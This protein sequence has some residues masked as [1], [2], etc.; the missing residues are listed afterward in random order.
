[1]AAVN[2]HTD[3]LLGQVYNFGVDLGNGSLGWLDLYTPDSDPQTMAL[4][5]GMVYS[6]GVDF[7]VPNGANTSAS[8]PQD[9][10]QITPLSASAVKRQ[11]FGGGVLDH[12]HNLAV[13]AYAEVN[14][15]GV[16]TQDLSL[17]NVATGQ[18]LKQF[19]IPLKGDNPIISLV[20]NNDDSKILAVT[21]DHDL[22]VI[23]VAAGTIQRQTDNAGQ[24]AGG[25]ALSSDGKLLAYQTTANTIR[26]VDTMNYQRVALFSN[27][28]LGHFEFTPDNKSLVGDSGLFQVGVPIVLD[29]ATAKM[30]ANA[31]AD[32]PVE[33]WR[34][35]SDGHY[36]GYISAKTAYLWDI[37]AHKSIKLGISSLATHTV[38]A[39]KQIASLT[40]SLDN[41]WVAYTGPERTVVVV[42]LQTLKPITTIKAASAIVSAVGFSKDGSVIIRCAG[43]NFDL[44][45]TTTGDLLSTI[46]DRYMCDKALDITWGGNGAYVILYRADVARWYGLSA[47]YQMPSATSVSTAQPTI[48][49]STAQPTIGSTNAIAACPGSPAP[50]LTIGGK[51]RVTPGNPNWI[52][53]A[54][55]R[56]STHPSQSKHIAQIPPGGVFDVLEGP[57][58]A[59]GITWWK[60]K[61]RGYT[62]WTGE[63]DSDYWVEPVN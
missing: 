28:Q 60:V 30:T 39:P 10:P 15:G 48:S 57:Q 52:N 53:T 51:G 8:N 59:D 63:S 25:M 33:L 55:L 17:N 54:A 7:H 1:M 35:S 3:P 40:F 21:Y 5:Y 24:F 62:G 6:T 20:L 9:A 4:I 45:N 47:D 46:T 36:I 49:V 37:A 2:I 38:T 61:Y 56:P 11:L 41:R 43:D 44:L 23:D 34:I 50:R 14:S 13:Q 18:T 31:P 32:G 27:L 42:D 16:F 12:L 19:T 26:V 29:I 58:C 22:I